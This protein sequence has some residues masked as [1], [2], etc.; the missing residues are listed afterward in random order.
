MADK[1]REITLS[2]DDVEVEVGKAPP[3]GATSGASWQGGKMEPG[4]D[5]FLFK[6]RGNTTDKFHVEKHYDHGLKVMVTRVYCTRNSL[7]TGKPYVI[8]VVELTHHH[9]E[10]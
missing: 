2:I 8:K 6:F 1:P 9:P 7:L 5:D 10:I 3:S 4:L